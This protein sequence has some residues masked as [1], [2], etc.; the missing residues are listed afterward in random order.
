MIEGLLSGLLGGL[1]GPSLAR[2]LR[3][4]KYWAI[5]LV[6]AFSTQLYFVASMLS[7]LG[8]QRTVESFSNGIDPVFF[9]V[10]AA[11]GIMAVIAALIGSLFAPKKDAGD[12]GDC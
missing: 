12:N 9:F 11:I 1:F 4:F 2:W 8:Y 7:K 3:K 5:F 10:P 6:A